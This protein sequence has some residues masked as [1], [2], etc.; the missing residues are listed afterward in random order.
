MSILG[1]IFAAAIAGSPVNSDS[2]IVVTT[3][4]AN[5]WIGSTVQVKSWNRPDVSIDQDVSGGTPN[6]VH[7]SIARSGKTITV[8]AEYTGEKKTYFFGLINVGSRKSFHWVVH[9]PVKSPVE[10]D[11]SN[12][13]IAVSGVTAPLVAVTSNGTINIDGSGPVVDARTSNG[14]IDASIATLA[15]G[16]PRV[17]L[18]TSN[19]RIGLHV[20]RGFTTHVEASTSNGHVDNPLRGGSGQG[21]ASARTSNGNIEITVGT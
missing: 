2:N 20:P 14:S 9:V 15:G 13:R 10:V 4:E 5:R 11:V 18:R 16:P 7:A 8:T 19:G 1:L 17:T 21:S 3:V 6:D 12:G